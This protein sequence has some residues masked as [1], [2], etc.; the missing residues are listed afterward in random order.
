MTRRFLFF[1][2]AKWVSFAF[3]LCAL[4]GC[5][6][7]LA[8]TL[9]SFGPSPFAVPAFDSKTYV[10]EQQRLGVNTFANDPQM[11]QERLDITKQ[12]GD[13]IL[14][15]ISTR[16]LNR[17][18]EDIVEFM[19]ENIPAERRGDF[20]AGWENYLNRGATFLQ[21]NNRLT[22]TTGEELSQ[23]FNRAFLAAL[24]DSEKE[25]SQSRYERNVYLGTAVALAILFLM[26]M[27]VPF[28]AAIELNTRV[29]S[30]KEML[31]AAPFV[32]VG[33]PCQKCGA[34]LAPDDMLCGECGARQE[35]AS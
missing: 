7:A 20:V 11:Q 16:A 15:V 6:Y 10:R 1:N 12:Y 19:Q 9:R 4:V 31:L 25:A 17:K 28:L 30:D 13:R 32:P 8:A 3:A 5:I 33:A 29:Q 23:S 2:I 34:M 14:A 24:R 18:L 21:E 35:K 26:A 27:I 22:N